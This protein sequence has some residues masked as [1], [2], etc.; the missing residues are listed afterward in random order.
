V[1]TVYT[2]EPG[3]E[4]TP[5]T[6]VH[7]LVRIQEPPYRYKCTKCGERLKIMSGVLVDELKVKGEPVPAQ[8]EETVEARKYHPWAKPWNLAVEARGGV[9]IELTSYP[10]REEGLHGLLIMGRTTIGDPTSNEVHHVGDLRPLDWSADK[11][12]GYREGF[13]QGWEWAAVAARALASKAD[14]GPKCR[15][16]G[17]PFRGGLYCDEC[18]RKFQGARQ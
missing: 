13:M 18:T 15:E 12:A 7:S 6:H 4:V 16:C 9:L 8:T 11:I 14:D 10:Y 1:P 5:G 3:V 2:E 17:K